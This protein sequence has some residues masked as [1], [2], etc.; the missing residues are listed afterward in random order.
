MA[1]AFPLN[2]ARRGAATG[3]GMMTVAAFHLPRTILEAATG[4]ARMTGAT[5]AAGTTTVI[6]L[7][8]QVCLLL[9]K[10]LHLLRPL[11]APLVTCTVEADML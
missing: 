5:P 9:A 6:Q 4:A 2:R 8:R 3:A 1:A 7:Q 10:L 11:E